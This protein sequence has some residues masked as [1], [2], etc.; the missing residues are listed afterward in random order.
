MC[1]GV[2]AHVKPLHMRTYL[3]ERWRAQ[4]S[5]AMKQWLLSKCSAM[6]Q[7]S[8]GRTAERDLFVQ[9]PQ[10]ELRPL[11]ALILLFVAVSGPAQTGSEAPRAGQESVTLPLESRG[12]HFKVQAQIN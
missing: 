7:T 1:H 3:D 2:R 12:G 5:G 9:L 4:E 8:R 11:L 6:D 10:P